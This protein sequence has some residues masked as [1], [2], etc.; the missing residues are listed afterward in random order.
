MKK[1]V[2]YNVNIQNALFIVKID[3][4]S[5]TIFETNHIESFRLKDVVSGHLDQT[6]I[7]ELLNATQQRY[8]FVLI[9]HTG[10]S[11]SEAMSIAYP[12]S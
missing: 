11:L 7:Y 6:G 2:I 4:N 1:G 10:L 12:K 8:Q 9:Q 3:E 5:Y